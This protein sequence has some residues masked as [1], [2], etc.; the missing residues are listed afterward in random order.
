MQRGLLPR[1]GG[2]EPE[3]PPELGGRTRGEHD[4]L[5]G[6]R[7]QVGAHEH[8]VAGLQRRSRRYGCRDP[9]DRIALSGERSVV[10]GGFLGLDQP[11]VG[12]H[13]VPGLEDHH[14]AGHQFP[15]G[16][17]APLAV[18]QHATGARHHRLQGLG[19]AFGGVLLR[20]TDAGVQQ[21]HA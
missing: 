21:H 5:R 16:Q 10:D 19:R 8:A 9:R 17:L 15:R 2:G 11:A 7:D 1:G 14:I 3:D 18:A 6:A 13:R 4:G 20:E 12:R